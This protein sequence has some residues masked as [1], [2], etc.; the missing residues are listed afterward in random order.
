[1]IAGRHVWLPAQ[2]RHTMRGSEPGKH[3]R[4]GGHGAEDQFVHG[5]IVR[6]RAPPVYAQSVRDSPTWMVNQPGAGGAIRSLMAGRS[7][8]YTASG[9]RRESLLRMG[10]PTGRKPDGGTGRSGRGIQT[11][12]TTIR[13]GSS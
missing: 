12:F 4:V 11:F 2:L 5:P 3:D 1:M 13:F 9:A 8:A 7:S 6:S 10:H